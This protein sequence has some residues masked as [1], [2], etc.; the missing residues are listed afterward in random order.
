MISRRDAMIVLGVAA[1]LTRSARAQTARKRPLIGW[2][3][4]GRREV[5]VSW[6]SAFLDGMRDLGYV[7][8]EGFDVAYRFADETTRDCGRS[9]QN[10]CRSSAT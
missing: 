7:E 4:S 9:W 2:L 6:I 3:D 10:W 5:V 8:G 1:T